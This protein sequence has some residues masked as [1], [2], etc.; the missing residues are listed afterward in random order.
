M[1]TNR[2]SVGPSGVLHPGAQLH[3]VLA[4]DLLR[5]RRRRRTA[6]AGSPRA[7]RPR[8]PRCG[9][10]RR[11]RAGAR[12]PRAPARPA[13]RALR[14]GLHPHLDAG[15]R[16]DLQ[17]AQVEPLHAVRRLGDVVRATGRAPPPRAESRPVGPLVTARAARASVRAFG[18]RSLRLP[19]AVRTHPATSSVCRPARSATR[20][21]RATGRRA[22]ARRGRRSTRARRSPARVRAARPPAGNRPAPPAGRQAARS[23]R[24]GRSSPVSA[25]SWL[26]RLTRISPR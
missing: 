4:L 16:R 11:R 5:R 10:R 21:G 13:G 1:P 23:G 6:T 19:S 2:R 8:C 17:A 9:A 14:V 12:C 22:R 26:I 15:D 18:R 25:R 7:P 3:A 20:A 24:H